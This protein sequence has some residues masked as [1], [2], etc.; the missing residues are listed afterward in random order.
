MKLYSYFRSSAAFRVRIALALKGLDYQ[1]VPIHLVK[2]G[3]EQTSAAYQRI[4]PQK[5][6]PTL[7]DDGL[8]VAQ[9][10]SIIEYLEEKYPQIPLLPQDI[11]NRAFV[12]AIAQ[13][14]ASDIHPLNNLRV[15][16]YLTGTLKIDDAQK[17]IWYAHWID[18]GFK[19]IETLL[20]QSPAHHSAKFCFGD[21][22]TLADCCLI[23]QV[24][25][26]KRFNCDLLAFPK[27]VTIYNHCMSLPA[28]IQAHPDNQSDCVN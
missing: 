21:S 7:D 16:Q 17:Q 10:L 6:V 13:M 19:A 24:Y 20:T 1:L 11:K 22:P 25:N 26:A 2:N 8:I 5:L 18:E 28:F 27:I 23:P 15:L 4:N 9:S 3:G 12:R 14:I